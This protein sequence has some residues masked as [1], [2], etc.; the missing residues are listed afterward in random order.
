MLGLKVYST[1]KDKCDALSFNT[2]QH[3]LDWTSKL[4]EDLSLNPPSACLKIK[5]FN[6]NSLGQHLQVLVVRREA[7]RLEDAPSLQRILQTVEELQLLLRSQHEHLLQQ[8]KMV[9][10]VSHPE[11]NS[12]FL[13]FPGVGMF[14]KLWM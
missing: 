2:E 13:T 6:N 12:I 4:E 1:F 3:N 11:L 10:L 5:T 9:I 7:G 14:I 8:L